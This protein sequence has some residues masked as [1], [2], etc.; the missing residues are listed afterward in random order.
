MHAIAGE[1]RTGDTVWFEWRS[2]S[3]S[4]ITNTVMDRILLLWF[5][6]FFFSVA[7]VAGI[8]KVLRICNLSEIFT[9]SRGYLPCAAMGIYWRTTLYHRRL[10]SAE[11]FR[12]LLINRPAHKDPYI[13]QVCPGRWILHAPKLCVVLGN[14]DPIIDDNEKGMQH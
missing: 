7:G 4:V 1:Q 5:L 8:W 2:A 3:L 13:S 6:F 14:M 10:L 12:R 11:S 9:R